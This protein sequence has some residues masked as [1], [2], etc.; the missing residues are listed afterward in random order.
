[1]NTKNIYTI[2]ASLLCISLAACDS[3]FDNPVSPGTADAGDA[4]FTTFVAIGDSLTAGFADSALYTSG[5]ENSFP[6]MLA[7]QFA[8]AGGGT[9]TQPLM[10]DD[11]GGMTVFAAP[12]AANRL[13]FDAVT[14]APEPAAGTADGTEATDGSLTGM[15]FNNLGVPGA[16]SF[17]LGPTLT[18]YGDPAAL[19]AANPYYI[20]MATATNSSM[21]ADA[22]AQA[23]TFFV[24]WIGNNDILGYATGGG[25]GVVRDAVMTPSDADPSTYGSEDITDTTV[26]QG[27]YDGLLLTLAAANPNAK[28]VLV[29]LPDVNAIPYFTTVPFNSVPLDQATADLLNAGYAA[30]NAG[31]QSALGF[32]GMTQDEVDARQITFVAGQN[33]VVIFDETLTDLTPANAAL[34][35][36]RQATADDLI[37]L[38]AS[39]KIG[40]DAGSGTQGIEFP[41]ADEDVLIPSE[42]AAVEAARTAFNAT[43]SAAAA[44]NPNLVLYDAA[45]DLDTLAASGIS[46]GGGTITDDYVTGGGFS[47]DGVHPTARGYAVI[48]NGIIDTINAGFNA[49]IPPVDPGAKTTVFFK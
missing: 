7:G 46:Y 24:L 19:P 10:G 21:I 35:S 2:S 14:S 26:F 15:T 4:D 38:P 5:Q 13:V 25:T 28:G 12:F 11:L 33:P 27:V 23:P 41:L 6:N 49:S 37:V 18:T 1:M 36:M 39:S 45:A 3:D 32:G 20:R 31:V 48:A 8:L 42:Q 29:N 22:A 43:I 30:Y 47:L 40:V 9:F 16:K 34:I 17:H 44:G